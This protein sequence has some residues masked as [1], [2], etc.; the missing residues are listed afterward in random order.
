[1][2]ESIEKKNNSKSGGTGVP[3]V[4]SFKIT[5]RNLPHW[6]MPDSIYFITWRTRDFQVLSST[7]RA[8]TLGAIKYWDGLKWTVYVAAVMPDHVHDRRAPLHRPEHAR[9]Q[10]F[11]PPLTLANRAIVIT[12]F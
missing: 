5:H 2:G 10:H 4:H 12:T 3:P 7:E 11:L 6:Q 8:T 9:R 1:M